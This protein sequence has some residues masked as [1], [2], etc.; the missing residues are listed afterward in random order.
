MPVS[1]SN[2]G[3]RL[4]KASVSFA[5]CRDHQLLLVLRGGGLAKPNRYRA[6]G[7]PLS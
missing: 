7:V 6:G 3:Q 1:A 4:W 2:F 5:G